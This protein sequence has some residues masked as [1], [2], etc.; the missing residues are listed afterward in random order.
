MT[1]SFLMGAQILLSAQSWPKN[2][3]RLSAYYHELSSFLS[4]GRNAG[5]GLVLISVPDQRRHK[6]SAVLQALTFSQAIPEPP[7]LIT[8]LWP[9]Y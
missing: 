5:L 3:L 6:V 1:N 4:N 2:L 9:Q 7:P 8:I